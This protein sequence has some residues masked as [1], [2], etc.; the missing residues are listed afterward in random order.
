MIEL[1]A[2]QLQSKVAIAFATVPVYFAPV[3]FGDGVSSIIYLAGIET[4]PS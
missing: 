4:P 3:T 2:S 1:M